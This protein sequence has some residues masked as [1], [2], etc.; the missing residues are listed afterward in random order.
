MSL[1]LAAGMA[2]ENIFGSRGRALKRKSSPELFVVLC[3]KM[4]PSCSKFHM[5]I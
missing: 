2:K 4:F 5:K 3:N 1:H